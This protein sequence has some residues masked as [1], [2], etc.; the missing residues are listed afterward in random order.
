MS[1]RRGDPPILTEEERVE[2]MVEAAVARVLR[3]ILTNAAETVRKKRDSLSRWGD[4]DS[5]CGGERHRAHIAKAEAT[6]ESLSE[7]A[8]TFD[9]LAEA[10]EES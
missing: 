5:M 3:D 2:K 8:D 1:G 4:C 6:R 10:V 9:T 7:L